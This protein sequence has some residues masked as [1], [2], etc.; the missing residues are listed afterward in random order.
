MNFQLIAAARIEGRV[1]NDVNNNGKI[2]PDEKGMPDV[3]ILLEPGNNNAYTD[4]DGK[5]TFEN[6]LPGKYKIR[7]DPATLPEDYVSHAPEELH[8]EVPVGGE[9]KDMNF[10]IYLKP[11]PIM[12]GPPKK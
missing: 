2:D 10:L 9:L 7:L 11:R 6:I 12:I 5:F 4:E 8:V 3:L 1:I